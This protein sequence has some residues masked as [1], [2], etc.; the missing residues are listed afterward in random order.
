[1]DGNNIAKL[2]NSERH[3]RKRFGRSSRIGRGDGCI[4]SLG[5]KL[6][7]RDGALG[8]AP[9]VVVIIL[10]AVVGLIGNR[11]GI[12]IARRQST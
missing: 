9:L 8:F 6:A 2:L 7:A 11:L 5:V 3:N 1:M 12:A 10:A 4:L